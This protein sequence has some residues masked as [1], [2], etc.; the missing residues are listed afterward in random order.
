MTSLKLEMD[1]TASSQVVSLEIS[2]ESGMRLTTS[3]QC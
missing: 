1:M 3:G 2:N